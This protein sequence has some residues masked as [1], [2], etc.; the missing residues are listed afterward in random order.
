MK[1]L[2]KAALIIILLSGYIFLACLLS[3]LPLF[4]R[5]KRMLRT[6]LAF[7]FSKPLLSLLGI[8]I[9]VNGK[10]PSPTGNSG[11]LIVAN[12]LS[13]LDVLIISSLVPSVFITS[14]ELRDSFLLGGLARLGGSLF[15]ERRSP[16]GL[17][18]EIESIRLVLSQGLA[19]VLFPEGTTSNGD[20]IRPFK[21]SLFSAALLSD[22]DV[23]PLCLRYTKV[24]G[25][26]VAASNRDAVFYYGDMTFF[27]HLSG[28]LSQE[29]VDI[30]VI[31]LDIIR[32]NADSSRKDLA[33]ETW[34]A[35]SRVYLAGRKSAE[36][37]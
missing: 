17:K 15:V 13:Y 10:I 6:R 9:Y 26:P 12:H 24:N 20:G 34:S 5:A 18:R 25:E 4:S 16:S 29:T 36:D 33:L 19:A 2:L 30:E 3:L 35:I 31:P 23:M 11:R 7:L 32:P 1:K 37:K 8:R 28:L 27:R 14:V 22:S 21:N